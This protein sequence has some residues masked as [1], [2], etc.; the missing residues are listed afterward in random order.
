M[1]TLLPYFLR[2][3][4]HKQFTDWLTEG[5]V[6]I[7]Q[8]LA[9]NV[10]RYKWEGATHIVY[11]NE[12]GTLKFTG[13][14]A[15]H[16]RAMLMDQPLTVVRVN[17]MKSSRRKTTL[18]KLRE[19]DGDRCFYCRDPMSF[20][21]PLLVPELAAT[22]EHLHPVSKGGDNQLS[23]LVLAHQSCNQLVGDEDLIT[24]LKRVYNWSK[25]T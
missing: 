2:D 5:G 1:E 20:G 21:A 23:N 6:V 3:F 16:Y 11:H 14:S 9:Y 12:K 22:V 25:P 4:A 10:I 7:E 24:K 17:R 19:R 15:E 13:D 8:P 18:E